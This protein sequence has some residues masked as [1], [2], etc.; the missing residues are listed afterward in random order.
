MSDTL[1]T[2]GSGANKTLLASQHKRVN[3][4]ECVFVFRAISWNVLCE[5]V[6]VLALKSV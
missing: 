4:C 2:W 3:V 6:R 5:V 1:V